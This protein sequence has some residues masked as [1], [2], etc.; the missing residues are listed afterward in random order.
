MTIPIANAIFDYK[1]NIK[2]FVETKNNGLNK[3]ENLRIF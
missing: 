3:I 2:D 1:L